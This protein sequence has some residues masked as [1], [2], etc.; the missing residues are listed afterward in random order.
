MEII[1]NPDHLMEI[2]SMLS[3]HPAAAMTIANGT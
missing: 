2:Y 1:N 3:E